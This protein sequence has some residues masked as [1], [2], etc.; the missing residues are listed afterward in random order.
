MAVYKDFKLTNKGIDLF[1][2]LLQGSGEMEFRYLAAGS[3]SYEEGESSQEYIRGMG[4]LKEERQRVPFTSVKKMDGGMVSLKAD[5]SNQGLTESYLMTEVGIYAGIAGSEESVLYCVTTPESPDCMPDFSSGRLYN[6]VFRTL[7]SIGDADEIT[8]V[9]TP[10]NGVSREEFDDVLNGL[11][12]GQNEDGRWGFIDPSTET[13]YP[14]TYRGCNDYA[15]QYLYNT[16][17]N[18]GRAVNAERGDMSCAFGCLVI[19][20]GKYSFAAGQYTEAVGEG[21]HAEGYGAKASGKN[22]HAEGLYTEAGG[23]YSHAEGNHTEANGTCTHAEGSRTRASNFSSHAGGCRNA[24]MVNT[25]SEYNNNGHAFVIGNGISDN[26]EGTFSN[27][28]SV[29]YDGAVKAASTITASTAADYAEYFEWED[30]NTAF[31]DRVGYFVTMD[32]DKIR[33]AVP[34]DS[35]ILGIVSGEPFVLGN[36]DCDVWNGMYL[37]DEFGRTIYERAPL[38]EPVEVLDED[39]VLQGIE[40]LPVLDADGKQLYKGT[41]PKINPDYNPGEPYVSRSDRPEWSP[42]GMLG[43]LSV[44][45]DGT[46]RVNG[47]CTCSEGGM[48]TACEE[49]DKNSYRVIKV[50]SGQVVKVVFR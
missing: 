5:L 50:I 8:V 16:S 41:R 43:V 24:E 13:F 35:Y 12:F 4:S 26:S 19:A 38:M 22:S 49:G 27:A 20:S 37:R 36:G 46:C 28:F 34:G 42:V 14:I 18:V 47:Y 25:K 15:S 39:G 40:W 32:G 33:I 11:K 45:Q 2:E 9:Y 17:V 3:G 44:R 1:T 30:G 21:A 6:V 29:M 7:I 31:E 48:A 10:D 23:E